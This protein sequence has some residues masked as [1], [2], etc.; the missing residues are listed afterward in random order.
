M[1]T[2]S[3][4]F[5]GHRHTHPTLEQY[6]PLAAHFHLI[7]N[8]LNETTFKT[9]SRCQLSFAS[10]F[11]PIHPNRRSPS[12][13]GIFFFAQKQCR[14]IRSVFCFVCIKS[15]TLS[16][17]VANKNSNSRRKDIVASSGAAL[18]RWKCCE[19]R[20]I[21][22]ASAKVPAR[23][24]RAAKGRLWRCQSVFGSGYT[25]HALNPNE[26]LNLVY[27]YYCNTFKFTSRC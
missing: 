6:Q 14:H 21:L 4:I 2:V 10:S 1:Q 23:L 13:H 9:N 7:P 8:A 19:F 25:S 3:F 11:A 15:S 5:V 16:A 18:G 24:L 20:S 27:Y 22:C 26:Q 12:L 17:S